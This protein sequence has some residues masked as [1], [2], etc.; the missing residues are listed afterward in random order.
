MTPEPLL[1]V[2]ATVTALVVGIVATVAA[3]AGTAV[4]IVGQKRAAKSAKQS[5]EFNAEV[6]AND[7]K[8]AQQSAAFEAKQIRRRNLLRLGSQRAIGAK[9][10][11]DIDSGG[12][13]DDVIFD[14]SIQG[15]LEA[16]ATEYSGRVAQGRAISRGQIALFE[17]QSAAD[18]ANLGALGAGISG[19]GGAAATGYNS[20]RGATQ[21]R[22][23]NNS[24]R[25]D[26]YNER[27]PQ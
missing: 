5:A 20:Y 27:G 13:L 3:L 9:S 4:S 2:V 26:L 11:I 10:G 7:A 14:S 19:I 6:A 21:P 16:Q 8:A 24:S 22:M 15:E 25:S 12:S 18:A 17:G 1:A 23:N